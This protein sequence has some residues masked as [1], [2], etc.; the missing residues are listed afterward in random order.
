MLKVEVRGWAQVRDHCDTSKKHLAK[1]EV[2]TGQGDWFE[3]N[4]ATEAKK[5][6]ALMHMLCFFTAHNIPME[7]I[8]HL[9]KMCRRAFPDSNIARSLKMGRTSAAYHLKGMFKTI[10]AKLAKLLNKRPFSLSFDAGTKGKKKRVEVIVRYLCTEQWKVLERDLYLIPANKETA[11]IVAGSLLDRLG[12]D[13]IDVKKNLVSV[14]TDSSAV[15]RGP[16]TGV[17]TRMGREASQIR[18]CDIGGDCLH[19][20]HNAFKKAAKGCLECQ[21]ATRIVDAVRADIALSPSKLAEYL[22]KCKSVGEREVLALIIFHNLKVIMISSSQVIPAQYSTIRWLSGYEAFKDRLE[23]IGTLREYY[24]NPPPATPRKNSSAPLDDPGSATSS[25]DDDDDDE[26]GE[27][28]ESD[29]EANLRSN[30]SNRLQLLKR[31]FNDAHIAKTELQLL[32]YLNCLQLGHEFVLAFQSKGV[33]IHELYT[34]LYKMMRQA[35]SYICEQSDLNDADGWPIDGKDMK[36]AVLETREEKAERERT[37]KATTVPH[38]QLLP[39]SDVRLPTD[40]IKGIQVICDKHRLNLDDQEDLTEAAKHKFFEFHHELVKALKHYLPLENVFL[41]RLR[42]LD[43]KVFVN[44]KGT[45]SNIKEIAK[46]LPNVTADELDDL[47]EE[48]SHLKLENRQYFDEWVGKYLNTTKEQAKKQSP[49]KAAEYKNG[50]ERAKDIVLVWKPILQSDR[51]PVLHKVLASALSI[52]H[53]TGSVEGAVGVTRQMLGERSHRLKT[54][55]MEI[56]KVV[57]SSIT[58]AET[59][60]CYDYDLSDKSYQETWREARKDYNR[61]SDTNDDDSGDEDITPGNSPHATP[62]NSPQAKSSES[63]VRQSG[64]AAK[65]KKDDKKVPGTKAKPPSISAQLVP[66]EFL[67]KQTENVETGKRKREDEKKRKAAK[68]LEN[69]FDENSSGDDLPEPPPPNRKSPT[70]I[71]EA[72]SKQKKA[73][74]KGGKYA[75]KL[76]TVKERRLPA[77]KKEELITDNQDSSEEE[78]FLSVPEVAAAESRKTAAKRNSYMADLQ[79]NIEDS[80]GWR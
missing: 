77:K 39:V 62:E 61:R 31:A 24:E 9:V 1:Y 41:Q 44:D 26:D 54:E 73:K 11:A 8:G 78:V 14:V 12:E 3:K 32:V 35:M 63:V 72:E 36:Q 76:K 45:W 38:I 58:S 79:F 51:F 16:H 59:D 5:H 17:M 18:A 57:K 33:K 60:C 43:P 4:A 6:I 28:G 71:S 25:D 22:K 65:Q 55:T 56:R 42:F 75:A 27:D 21:E 70:E 50:E 30:A 19:H 40:V 74:I 2:W 10:R 67:K 53:A 20:V 23:H 64:S 7:N 29:D 49:E 69:E 52:F 37:G 66:A 80:E 34:A 48:I 15:N 68:C 46:G 13:K 47:S